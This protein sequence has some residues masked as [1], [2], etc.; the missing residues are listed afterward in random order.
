MDVHAVAL[1]A[2]E[3]GHLALGEAA[4]VGEEV[5]EH[6]ILS[7]LSQQIAGHV[8][9]FEAEAHQALGG[10]AAFE[11][12]LH[13][14][15]HALVEAGTQTAL[16]AVDNLLSIKL[17]AEDAVLH[18]GQ[19]GVAVGMGGGV[20]LYLE[21]ADEAVAGLGVGVVVQGAVGGEAVGEFLVGK[22]LKR[23]TIGGIDGCVA[24]LVAPDDGIDVEAG[25]ATKDGLAA[26]GGDVL[27][28]ALEVV[29]EAVG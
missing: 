2:A 10:D 25:A 20:L 29:Q 7:A 9:I 11:Q 1:H 27:V 6:L 28:G 17:Y 26:A 16:D 18:V 19:A 13:L 24:E 12:S 21:G 22:R 14:V 8:A 4:Y 15:G 5:A 3:P 23:S